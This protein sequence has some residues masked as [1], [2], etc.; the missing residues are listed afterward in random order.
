M[1][2]I[3]TFGLCCICNR[4]YWKKNLIKVNELSLYIP[5]GES[6][7]KAEMRWICSKCSHQMD[8][9]EGALAAKYEEQFSPI[10]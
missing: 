5:F 8:L 4:A 10:L 7:P 9:E 3:N 2:K 6:K 1:T